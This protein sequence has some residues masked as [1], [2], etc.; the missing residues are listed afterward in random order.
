MSPL[1]VPV[2]AEAVAPQTRSG[3]AL[4]LPELEPMVRAPP[5]PLA[6]LVYY[7]RPRVGLSRSDI[8]EILE[9]ARACN[10]EQAITGLL[11]FRDDLF[12]QVLEGERERVSKLY[13]GIST[14]PRHCDLRLVGLAPIDVRHFVDWSMGYISLREANRKEILRY[15]ASGL[16]EP[17]ALAPEQISSILA[18][19]SRFQ[20]AGT[21]Q[22]AAG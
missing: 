18:G 17:S 7:S 15:S 22:R 4:K 3:S 13:A 6:R 9:T 21:D 19:L 16:F 5:M 11:G 14:D 2:W 8:V 1:R 20:D 10:G 12:V